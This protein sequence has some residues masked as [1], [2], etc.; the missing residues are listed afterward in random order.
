MSTI[1]AGAVRRLVVEE[2]PVDHHDRRVVARRVALDALERDP[3]V[4]RRLVVP[5]AEGVRQVLPDGVATHDRAQR[6]DADADGV[7]PVGVA[8][9]LRVEGRHGRDLGGGQAQVR[10]AE[11]DPARADVAV[12]RLHEVQH[13]Q[14]RRPRL[15]VAGDDQRP[16]PP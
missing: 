8:L 6:V 16:S 10:R 14:Q 11:R 4:V 15:R 7:V 5:D 2:L 12:L 13:R 1:S 9:V 3:A